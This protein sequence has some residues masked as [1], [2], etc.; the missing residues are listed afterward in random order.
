MLTS[1]DAAGTFVHQ[2]WALPRARAHAAARVMARARAR[3]PN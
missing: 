2:A 1:R 3:K